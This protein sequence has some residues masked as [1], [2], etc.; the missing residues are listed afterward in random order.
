MHYRNLRDLVRSAFALL[1]SRKE[2]TEQSSPSGGK[3]VANAKLQR[4]GDAVAHAWHAQDAYRIFK[5]H[6]N[7]VFNS[8]LQYI[9]NCIKLDIKNE[10]NPIHLYFSSSTFAFAPTYQVEHLNRQCFYSHWAH[11]FPHDAQHVWCDVMCHAASYTD[12]YAIPV[13]HKAVAEVSKIGH[14]RRGELLWCM[15][16]RANPL[17]DRKVV[18]VVFFEVAAV[19]AVAA[20]PTTAGWS[21]V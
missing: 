12:R 5:F 17:M 3:S 2:S 8:L 9:Q 13:P 15:D 10:Y 16:G 14:H 20:S 11:T 1:T 18:G 4:L 21:V 6:Q 19:V 7:P